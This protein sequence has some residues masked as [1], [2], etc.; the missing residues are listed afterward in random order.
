MKKIIIFILIYAF[1][2]LY[3]VQ[4]YPYFHFDAKKVKLSRD[5]Y[6]RYIRP[7]IRS[8]VQEFYFILKKLDPY[9]HDIIELN[10]NVK[11]LRSDW[12]KFENQCHSEIEF[13]KSLLSKI[14]KTI[15]YLDNKVAAIQG[16]L[17]KN[18]INKII[19]S[20]NALTNIFIFKYF[21]KQKNCS[22]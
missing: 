9:N 11:R 7:Q 6:R 12:N 22:I 2:P 20:L 3:K 10:N 5:S 4:S 13:C 21:Y 8:I 19:T 15:S 17:A 1:F 18:K 14:K 16:S